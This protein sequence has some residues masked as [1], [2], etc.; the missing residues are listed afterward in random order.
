MLSSFFLFIH[1]QIPNQME[2]FYNKL[3]IKIE[4]HTKFNQ[5]MNE[6]VTSE[7]VDKLCKRVTSI[8]PIVYQLGMLP[9][10]NYIIT[11]VVGNKFDFDTVNNAIVDII[12]THL[13]K[14]D[15][16]SDTM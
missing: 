14:Q 6:V 11:K 5:D 13:I 2:N 10:N 3:Y 1:H 12:D 9:E 7:D 15:V 16:K 4:H 8:F